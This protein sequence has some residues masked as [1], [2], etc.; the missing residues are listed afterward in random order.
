MDERIR[1][2]LS[3]PNSAFESDFRAHCQSLID[4]S[5][6]YMADNYHG[7]WQKNIDSYKAQRRTDEKDRK[8][9]ARG[10]PRKMILPM[11]YS[12][13]DT[14][15]SF[16]YTLFTQKDMFYELLANGAEDELA[17]T[18]AES[19]LERDLTSSN[20]YGDKLTQFL[21]DVAVFD[22]GIIKHTWANETKLT[23]Q[24]YIDEATG[25]T[26][27]EDVEETVFQGNRLY[28]IN[29]FRFFPDPRMPVTQFQDGEFVGSVSEYS[30]H[31][32]RRMEQEGKIVGLDFVSKMS[33]DQF[34]RKWLSLTFDQYST[35]YKQ[36]WQGVNP[37]Y[38][39]TEIQ[40][41]IIPADWTLEDG[42]PLGPETQVVKY[43][44]WIL[45]DQRLVFLSPLNYPHDQFTYDVAVYDYDQNAFLGV[46]LAELLETLQDT[47]TWFVNSR[48]TS[49]RKVI[50]NR[51]IV[52]P[53]GIE[54]NDLKSRSP[55]I[56]LKPAM[57]GFGVQNMVT[58]LNL[59]DVTT[60][61]LSDVQFL[62]QASSRATGITENLMGLF[63]TGR[64]SASEA[65]AV[66]SNAT[67][68]LKKIAAG[69]WQNGLRPLGQ[70]LL[71]NL[72]SGMDAT[73]LVRIIGE[74]RFIENIA[75]VQQ[76][77]HIDRS[78]FD[79]SF[80]FRIFD[81][82]LP[83]E[84][85]LIAEGLGEMLQTLLQA[86]QLIEMFGLNLQELFFEYLRMK[87]IRNV[88]RFR[89]PQGTTT[90]GGSMGVTPDNQAALQQIVGAARERNFGSAESSVSQFSELLTSGTDS[91]G[92]AGASSDSRV[93]GDL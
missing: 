57:A 11:T 24:S 75:G 93:P 63:A 3:E 32:L 15:V 61:H 89:L 17:K 44:A 39:L 20:W 42:K 72:R 56:R 5:Y 38:A 62:E 67:A 70:K 16:C 65:R 30:K 81:G 49:V 77:M 84:K 46:S 87:G 82:T 60:N 85:N 64:R 48:I 59:Q 23:Q 68:R 37:P 91:R 9:M 2:E 21:K 73:Q 36:G 14:F 79:A 19:V 83:S 28:C 8:A 66:N 58:Q 50:D 25:A 33:E 80:D 26:Q 27:V 71:T 92:S 74:V 55:V 69:I 4:L 22:L 12:Q 40:L 13:V 47:A 43:V 45:N 88:E 52:D 90:P 53:K 7:Q 10:E 31:Q 1:K 29:P 76:F 6:D 86:P 18:I 41:N 35:Y 34:D 78:H 54:M 51:L